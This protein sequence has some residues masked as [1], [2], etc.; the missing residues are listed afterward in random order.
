MYEFNQSITT[1]KYSMN[2]NHTTHKIQLDYMF[3]MLHS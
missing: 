1:Y 3:V 2:L